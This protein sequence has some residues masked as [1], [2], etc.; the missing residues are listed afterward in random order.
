LQAIS[1]FSAAGVTM[2]T[3]GTTASLHVRLLTY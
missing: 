3:S 1:V 2:R